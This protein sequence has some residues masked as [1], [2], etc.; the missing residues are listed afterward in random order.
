MME[1]RRKEGLVAKKVLSVILII[2]GLF[3]TLIPHS[4]HLL[5]GLNVPHMY[6]VI[7][8]LIAGGIGAYLMFG[9]KS[10]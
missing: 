5:F 3:F 7:F 10:K 8:G 9:K 2:V 6:H 1:I 4:V